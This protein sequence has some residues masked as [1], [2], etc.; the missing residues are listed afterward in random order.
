MEAGVLVQRVAAA[1]GDAILRQHHGQRIFRHRHRAMLIAMDDGDGR[2][3]VALAA[4][5]PVAQA[6]GRLLFAQALGGQVARHRVH[7]GLVVQPVVGA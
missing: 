1:I 6:P 3:P 4:D 2:A 5:T 7:C